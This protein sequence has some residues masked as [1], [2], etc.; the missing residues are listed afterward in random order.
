[1][2]RLRVIG[3]GPGGAGFLTAAAAEAIAGADVVWCAERHAALVPPGK[4]RPL[5]PFG[6]AIDGMEAALREGQRCAVLLSGDPGLYS[7]LPRLKER[8]GEEGLS[9]LPSVSS[10]QVLC[11]ALGTGWEDARILSAHGRALSPSALCY[12]VRAHP[13]TMVLLDGEKNP[14]WVRAAL[15]GGGLKDL[16]FVVGERLCCEGECVASYEE[17]EY[18]PLSVAFIANDTPEPGLPPVGI[19]DG[20]FIR[21]KTPMTKREIRR[22]IV[23]ELGLRPDSVVWDVGAGTG[24]VSIE[25]SGQCPLGSV[26]AVEREEE[27]LSLIGKN[28]ERF[29]A[30]NLIAV[31]GEAPEALSGLPL[32]THVFLGGTG[33]RAREILDFLSCLGTRIRLVATAVTVENAAFYTEAL[34]GYGDFTAAQ[35]AVSRLFP[36][37]GIHLLRAEN[38]VFVFS[39]T[40]EGKP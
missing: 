38:P 35:I 4:H 32:P 37:G 9:V 20:E 23:G 31:S 13:K 40:L 29:F 2:N 1:M 19:P 36:A 21:G 7:L 34:S 10:V 30:Q 25:C 22:Q 33:G 8:F 39:A 18:D 3:A 14:H 15:D 11:A 12:S 24:S 16:P 17:R 27:A 28:R 6:A 5:L 26:F